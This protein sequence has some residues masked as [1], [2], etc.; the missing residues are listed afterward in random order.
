MNGLSAAE[1]V[2]RIEECRSWMVLKNVERVPEYRELLDRC[3]EDVREHAEHVLP[4]MHM[5]EAFVFVSSPGSV[6]PFHIDPEHNFL[7]QVR[8]QKTIHVFDP[9][10]RQ[11]VGPRELERFYAGGHRNIPFREEWQSRASSW[12]LN[13]G[14]GVHVPVTAPHWVRNG[15]AVS[16]SF[17]VTFRSRSSKRLA[18]V[19][20]MNHRLRSLGLDPAPA[21]ASPLGDLAK[22]IANRAIRG[23]MSLGE[24]LSQR[25]ARS[26][27]A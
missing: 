9:A 17:S 1:T 27:R 2:R 22:Q 18:D 20:Q 16:V 23:G 5:P 3:L 14:E 6:T 11:L 19:W 8:G 25:F 24:A 15:D 21:G 13:P 12:V 7:F 4:G 26:A 10:D